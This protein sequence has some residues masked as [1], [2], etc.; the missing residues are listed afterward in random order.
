MKKVWTPKAKERIQEAVGYWLSQ[1]AL[2][3][4]R[5]TYF[6]EETPDKENE[7]TLMEVACNHPY[8]SANIT[9]YPSIAEASQDKL[10]QSAC[11]EVIHI[12]LDPLDEVR[13][14]DDKH[15]RLEVERVTDHLSMCL[16]D[17]ARK[18]G[19]AED[20]VKALQKP[21]KRKRVK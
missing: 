6:F 11:H 8:R 20:Q 2:T 12:V 5:V 18:L 21:S 7:N 19:R 4:F 10:N 13:L 15:W 1:L 16:D 3:P 14:S 9:S 17:L